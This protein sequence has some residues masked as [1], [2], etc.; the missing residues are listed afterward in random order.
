MTSEE[1]VAAIRVRLDDTLNPPRV[2]TSTI[3][4][5]ASLTQC[6]FARSTLVLFD[7]VDVTVTPSTGWVEVPD[8]FF[9]LKTAILNGT[10]LRSITISELDFGYYSF[11]KK[12]NTERFANWRA[13]TGTPKFIVTDMFADRARLVPY[14]QTEVVVSLEGYVIPSK[15][16]LT[17]NPEIPEAYHEL[18]VSGTLMRLFVLFDVDVLNE[19]KAQ[20]YST[21]WY[22]GLAE[23]QNNLRTGLRRQMRIMELPRGFAFDV[24]GPKPDAGTQQ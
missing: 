6:E 3:L 4:E 12:E 18:L 16:S 21:Q 19:S 14:P 8:N 15:L 20:V 7:T 9:F 11:N 2:S 10:Q 13:V 1:L 22:Q 23:A 24:P 5:Q 17:V